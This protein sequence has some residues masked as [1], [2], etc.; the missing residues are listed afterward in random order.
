MQRHHRSGTGRQSATGGQRS[1]RGGHCGGPARRPEPDH[2]V[3]VAVV[4]VRGR[5]A[6]GRPARGRRRQQVHDNRVRVRDRQAR[7]GAPPVELFRALDHGVGAAGRAVVPSVRQRRR[8]SSRGRRP[9]HGVHVRRRRWRDAVV[10]VR[11]RRT[12]RRVAGRR[13]RRQDVR[14]PV[15]RHVHR[16]RV[17][18]R[19]ARIPDGV[20]GVQETGGRRADAPVFPARAP[21]VAAAARERRPT[22]QV[23]E[24]PGHHRAVRTSAIGAYRSRGGEALE[25]C[26]TVRIKSGRSQPNGRLL[27]RPPESDAAQNKYCKKRRRT[28]GYAAGSSAPST[29]SFKFTASRYYV[30]RSSCPS[31][32]GIFSVYLTTTCC[33]AHNRGG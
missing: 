31:D 14:V 29:V 33:I 24:A 21:V 6:V 10:S 22:S 20:Q 25:R 2:V 3:R 1:R 26:R 8:R 23:R 15:V 17:P 13:A 28:A 5:P 7:G 16:R 27:A 18:V 11:G 30:V 4:A 12:S 19:V 32:F 9:H